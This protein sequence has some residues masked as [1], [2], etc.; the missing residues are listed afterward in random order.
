MSFGDHLDELRKRVLLSIALPIPLA[1]VAFAFGSTI[2]EILC[3]PAYRALAANGMPPQLQAL[4]PIEV[5]GADMHLALVVA[6]VFSGPWIVWQAWKFVEPGLYSSEKRFVR[7]LIPLSAVLTATGV[8]IVYFVML[9][10]MLEF[11]VGF[12]GPPPKTVDLAVPTAMPAPASED[13]PTTT[14]RASA[15][16]IPE[17]PDSIEKPAVAPVIVPLLQQDPERPAPGQIWLTPG[18]ELRLAVPIPGGTTVEILGTPLKRPSRLDQQFRLSEYLSLV[19]TLLMATAIAFQLPL[20]MMLLGW[21]GI[22]EVGTLRGYR[23][24]ALFVCAILAAII[25]PTVDP[26]SMILMT[27]PL[28]ALYELGI[29]LLVIAPP[30]AVAEGSIWRRLKDLALGRGRVHS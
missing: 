21:I 7:F 19:L 17:A 30:R 28:Y 24:H 22:I 1:I 2:R 5:I 4:N 14:P 12:G 29:I 27:I 23:R 8:L 9:P 25:T 20:V 26:I 18:H 6:L 16:T 13:A 11:L 10:L 3:L 15:P